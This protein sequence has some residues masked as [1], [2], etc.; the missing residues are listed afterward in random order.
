MRRHLGAFVAGLAA[1]LTL[2]PIASARRQVVVIPSGVPTQTPTSPQASGT[3][4]LL[5][6]VIDGTSGRPV[7]GATVSVSTAQ[8]S[9]G[10]TPAPTF[11]TEQVITGSDGVFA[12]RNLPTG[13]FVVRSTALGYAA[14]PGPNMRR[15][16]GPFQNVT[17]ADGERLNDVVMRLWKNAVVTG[18]VVD[19][20]GQRFAAV[21]HCNRRHDRVVVAAL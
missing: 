9:P 4:L 8:P 16:G 7:T 1:V 5:G 11:A 3:G 14:S 12:F 2:A 10:A 18:Q 17:L 21:S 6:H 20:Q 15:P 19:D 13:E